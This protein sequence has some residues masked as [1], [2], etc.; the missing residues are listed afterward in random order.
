MVL[1][2][3]GDSSIVVVV[4]GSIIEVSKLLLASEEQ[5]VRN[6]TNNTKKTPTFIHYY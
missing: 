2:A 4:L 6:I 1:V 5:E 3:S